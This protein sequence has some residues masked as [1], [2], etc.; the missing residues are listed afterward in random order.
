[1]KVTI[2]GAGAYGTALGGILANNGYDVDYYDPRREKE[3]LKDAVAG[4]KY[5]VL[6]TP[7]ETAAHLLPLL[8]KDVPLVVASKGFLSTKPFERFKKWGALSGPG[9]AKDIKAGLD[10]YLTVT[11]EWVAKLFEADYLFFDLAEDKLAVLMCGALKNVYAMLAGK[12]GLV[13]RTPAMRDYLEDASYEMGLVL[14]AN[15]ADRMTIYLACGVGDLILTATPESRNYD[16]GM[17][18]RENPDRRPE[19]TVECVTTLRRI[20]QGEIEVPE[21]AQY[22]RQLVIDS[23]NWE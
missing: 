13:P 7:S 6:C 19:G 10:T 11:D 22:L 8:P 17:K 16:F 23:E 21:T 1:M 4:A 12:F 3:R 20:R 14:E 9:F 15:G 18:L 2:L 5:L